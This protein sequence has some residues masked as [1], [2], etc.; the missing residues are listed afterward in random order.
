MRDSMKRWIP[1]A[2]LAVAA[3]CDSPTPPAPPIGGA[4]G[5]PQRLRVLHV[6]VAFRGAYGARETVTRTQ[7]EAEV[8]AREI[9]A[10]AR[11]GEDFK[12]L[13]KDYSNDSGEGNYILVNH[14][15]VPRGAEHKR[16][17]FALGFT[18]V[19]WSLAVDEI[20][21]APYHKDSTPHGYHVIKR[22][23]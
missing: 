2:I 20:G 8:L 3:G 21:L 11:R 13:M 14:G 6:L 22:I 1:I 9:L 4:K 12:K 17:D 18:T 19:A 23:E 7:D 15:V 10:R 5:E 16:A